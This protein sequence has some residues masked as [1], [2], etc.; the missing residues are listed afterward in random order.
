MINTYLNTVEARIQEPIFY[1]EKN[2]LLL[3]GDGKIV[4]ES[5]YARV[6]YNRGKDL[7]DLKCGYLVE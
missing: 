4:D 3:G 2:N 1:I 5:L 7:K 6:K